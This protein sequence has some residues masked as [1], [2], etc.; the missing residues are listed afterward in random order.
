MPVSLEWVTGIIRA[1]EH[2]NKIED[3]FEITGTILKHDTHAIL[4]GFAGVKYPK[5]FRR[6][7]KTLLKSI[8]I[9]T[10]EWKIGVDSDTENEVKGGGKL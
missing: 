5:N 6:D 9:K 3:D 4:K 1:G 8:G 10:V 7:M 2:H